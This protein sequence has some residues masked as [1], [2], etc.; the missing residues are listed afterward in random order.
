MPERRILL[1]SNL[2]VATSVFYDRLRLENISEKQSLLILFLNV[3]NSVFHDQLR[4]KIDF[5]EAQFDVFKFKCCNQ[6]SS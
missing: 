4:L 5:R 6:Y 3:T 1:R 2:S